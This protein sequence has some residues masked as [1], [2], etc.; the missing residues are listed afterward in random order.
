[1]GELCGFRSPAL[2]E[3]WPVH[4]V[5]II[6]STNTEAKRR[7][8][9]G[10]QD[11]WIVAS[12]QSAGRGRQDRQWL[13]PEGNIYATALFREPEG[14]QVAL[15]LPFA[16]AL[17]VHD[18]VAAHAPLADA[19][20]K[21]PND[22]RIDRKKVSGIL[23]ETGGTGRDFWIAA[24]IGVNV[25]ITPENVTQPAT[26]LVE[27]GM[28]AAVGTGAVLQS[29]RQ[30]FGRR[31][32]QARSGFAEIRDAWKE[33]AEALG[34]TLHIV[35]GSIVTEAVFVDLD[36]DGALVVQLPDGSRRSIRAGEVEIRR[37]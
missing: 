1:M 27:L 16:C 8:A 36:T 5:G 9:T 11:H 10:F 24:G 20:L 3:L 7:V 29:L 37:S 12:Q 34:E 4:Q 6:D 35:E 23:V 13:S 17:A 21:W 14:L 30:A 33:R 26:S 31:L 2:S 22:V 28:P 15:R 32:A 19:R 18:V 25:L